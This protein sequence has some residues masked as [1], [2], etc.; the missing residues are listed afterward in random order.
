[1][2][3]IFDFARHVAQ[4][5]FDALPGH[6][7]RAAKTLI[8]DTLGVGMVGSAGPMAEELAVAQRSSGHGDDARVWSLGYR[9]PA[10]AAALCNAYQVHNSEFDCVHEDAVAHVLSAVVPAALA[11]AER[12]GGISG[13]QLLTAV[14]VGV[15]VA[16]SLGIAARAGLKFFRPATVGA[17]GAA[18]AVG[19]LK[20]F[21]EVRLVNALSL[22]YGQ[23]CGTMQAHTEGSMLL[24]MQMGFNARNAVVACDLAAA[25]FDGPKN[26][27]EGPFGFFSLFEPGGETGSVVRELGNVWRIAEVAHKPFP[28]GRATHGIVDGCLEIKRAH[29]ILP[30]RIARVT[31]H[32]PPLVHHLV[33]RRPQA[34]MDTNY[35]R[36]CAAYVAAV[37]LLKDDVRFDDFAAEAYRD[38]RTQEL[39]ARI[40]V[41]AEDRGDPNA[42]TPVRVEIALDDGQVHDTTIDAV[43]GNPAKAMSRE[44]Q[45][46]KFATNCELAK[47][48]LSERQIS[49]LADHVDALEDV[50]D[51][52]ILVDHMIGGQE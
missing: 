1:M 39:A 36:L 18:A 41:E 46:A 35:A 43:Y 9:L 31:A 42:L 22:T 8:L 4:T 21:D 30:E 37:A 13:R 50:E 28:S 16:S 3:A 20:G 52:A 47:R 5:E 17:F 44:A 49:G 33:G 48:P 15:D 26:I 45:L 27:L 34:V 40:H 24:A 51:V 32:V 25:G 2:D 19:K 12:R 23:L 11:Y 38:V 7:V 14:V 10:P 6:A 29:G